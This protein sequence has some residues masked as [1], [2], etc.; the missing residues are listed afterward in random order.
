MYP[1]KTL[2]VVIICSLF[3]CCKN[4][5]TEVAQGEIIR[6]NPH[7]AA[8]YVNLSEIVDSISCVRLLI[9]PNEI[10]GR[11]R[12]IVVKKNHIYAV[13]GM[14]HAVFVFDKAGNFLSKLSKRGNGPGEYIAMG[15]VFI[16]EKEEYV[17]ILELFAGDKRKK[18]KYANLSFELLEETLFPDVS[19]RCRYNDG[20]YCFVNQQMDNLVNG[21][22]T[23]AGLIITDEKKIL[24]TFFDK[25]IES[26]GVSFSPNLESF[27][28]NDEGDLF[29]SFMYDNTFYQLVGDSA[30]PIL[31]VDFGK[32]GIENAKIG[33]LPVDKQMQYLKEMSGLASFPVLNV[34]NS[35]LLTFSYYFKEEENRMFRERDYRQYI[36]L[37]ESGK[38]YHTGYIKNDLTEF[39]ERVYFSTYFSQCAH[40]VWYEDY[41]VDVVIPSF[42]FS[43]REQTEIIV[44]GLGKITADDDPI[45]VLMKLKK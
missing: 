3:V 12:E 14:Q 32:Y 4:Q 39:P 44:E 37:K 29:A 27:T 40:E 16:D 20:Y 35:D 11:V 15:P 13:D 43:E 17:E 10:M 33:L 31:T 1:K 28:K 6:I 19:G 38:T 22:K 36:Y 21:K 26:N 42:Y 7:E 2:I 8:E 23:N 30:K 41:I 18:R 25:E 9:P 24:K 5:S 34:N 45:V